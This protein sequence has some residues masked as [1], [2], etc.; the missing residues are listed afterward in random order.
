VVATIAFGMG[1]NKPDVRFVI[2]MSMPGSIEEYYQESGRA[3]RDGQDSECILYY[4]P[5]DKLKRLNFTTQERNAVNLAENITKM[6]AYC[7]N[8]FECRRVLQL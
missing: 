6:A 5:G 1:I 8:D 4:S 7:E 2:H 3:G